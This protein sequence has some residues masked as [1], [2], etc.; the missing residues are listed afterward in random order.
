MDGHWRRV[1]PFV[2]VFAVL[3]LGACGSS[4]QS[5]PARTSTSANGSPTSAPGAVTSA[6]GATRTAATTGEAS[7]SSTSRTTTTTESPTTRTSSTSTSTTSTTDSPTTTVAPT[8]RAPITQPA[9][10]TSQAPTAT[11][12]IAAAPTSSSD[13]GTPWGWIVAGVGVVVVIVG[14]VLFARSRNAQRRADGWRAAVAPAFERAVVTRD[15]LVNNEDLRD[16]ATRRAVEQQVQ[17]VAGRLETLGASA[18]SVDDRRA[19]A[20]AG[21]ALRGL[22]FAL[23]A[24][25]LLRDGGAPTADQLRRA[26]RT[27]LEQEDALDHALASLQSRISPRADT[28]PLV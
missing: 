18:P 7:T 20:T 6:P 23:E 12:G 10:P 8:T 26:D 25:Q 19:A 2:L 16:P 24:Q 27:R 15:L 22:Y 5:R 13:S 9:A 28:A 21:D 14:G 3:L 11:S 1:A 4:N 17:E